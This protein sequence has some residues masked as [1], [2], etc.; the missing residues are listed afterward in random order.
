MKI[1]LVCRYSKYEKLFRV[2]RIIWRRGRG[3]GHGF[4]YN[5]DAF[6]SL[7]IGLP[8]FR[9]DPSHAGWRLWLG[10]IRIH[11]HTRYG[12]CLV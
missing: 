4:P 10:P 6:F 3:P 2:G 11:R 12:G 7:A 9:L 5:Y 8:R 1:K